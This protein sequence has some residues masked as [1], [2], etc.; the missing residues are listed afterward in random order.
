[1]IN[2]FSLSNLRLVLAGGWCLGLLAVVAGLVWSSHMGL[3]VAGLAGVLSVCC[4]AGLLT[5]YRQQR[6]LDEL[7]DIVRAAANGNMDARVSNRL[8][9]GKLANM[10]NAV[11]QL[12][13]LTE[14]FTKEA[15]A[16]MNCAS[17]GDYFRKIIPR[18]L[19]GDLVGY[20][21]KV[22]QALDVMDA[23]TRTFRNSAGQIGDDLK[24][25]VGDLSDS[26]RKLTT[27]SDFLSQNV[28]KIAI[29]AAEMRRAADESSAALDGIATATE[30]FSG[31]IQQIGCQID[32]S[33]SLSETAV[34][35]ARSA[36]EHMGR[37]DALAVRVTGVVELITDVA[38]QTNLL[39]LNAS[40]EAARAGDAGKGFSVVA[41]EVKNLA[42]QTA[43]AAEQVIREIGQMQEM[44]REAVISVR[45]ISET[46]AEI[47]NGARLVA[48]ATREQ[49]AAVTE[50][51]N[52]IEQAV[53]L[54]RDIVDS[55]TEVASGTHASRDVLLALHD[56]ATSLLGRAETL[57][58]DVRHFVGTVLDTRAQDVA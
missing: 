34:E 10:Q 29:Q 6:Y 15:A 16:A 8:H 56:E 7:C 14:A 11:N 53:K 57:D 9:R 27:N 46:I 2:L 32:G 22:N 38:D 31:S 48:G 1:M 5:I 3:V 23:Q 37:L 18:G 25:V 26:A 20:A 51:G 17:R 45:D 52:R 13:D 49:T 40:I 50:I 43:H 21:Q 33:A 41:S 24:L 35:R 28:G 42:S 19:R 12:L 54:M 55:V 47:D 39:A 44:T 4:A 30:Q 58:G 36:G